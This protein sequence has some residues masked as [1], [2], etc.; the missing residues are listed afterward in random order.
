[1][2]VTLFWSR[3]RDDLDEA[4]MRAYREDAGRIHALAESTPGFI[5]IKTYQAEDGE[6]LSVV[7]FETDAQQAE[8]RALAEHRAAQQRGRETYYQSYRLMVCEPVRDYGWPAK[9]D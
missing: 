3:F 6:R 9:P 7:M 8:F 2:P 1:M 5:S 4:G